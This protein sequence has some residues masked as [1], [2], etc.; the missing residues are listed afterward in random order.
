V[1]TRRRLLQAVA[2]AALTPVLGGC[3][4]S[5]RRKAA[6]QG[7][8]TAPGRTPSDAL[9]MTVVNQT[10]R[11]DNRSIWMYVVG[12]DLASGVQGYV[13]G[14]GLF[15]RCSAADNGPDG[16]ADFAIPL[17]ASGE[18]VM[19]L[20]RM[21]GRVYFA[22]GSKLR[23][24]VVD[25]S[26][27]QYPSPWTPGDANVSVLHDCIEFTHSPAGMFCNTTMVD[28]FSVPMALTLQG[29]RTQSTGALVAGGRRRIFEQISA[30]AAYR[31]LVV[32]DMRVVAPSHG[33]DAGLFPAGYFDP[34]ID[35]VWR[36]Y[37]AADLRVR[38]DK[39]VFTGRVRDHR[40]VFDGGVRPIARPSTRDALFCDG[41]LTAPNDG[42]TGP[43]A[44]VLGAGFNRSVLAVDAAQPVLDAAKFYREPVANHYAAVIHDNAADG[45]AYGFAF[46]DVGG[47]ASYIEDPAPQSLTVKLTA[48]D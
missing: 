9:S 39:G 26:R 44:A 45:R 48:F 25:G 24:R 30:L 4:S 22:L 23:F 42:V 11:F 32:G 3:D 40:L 34:M 10:G 36:R 33:L 46:D 2:A 41:A 29:A 28:M 27:L 5:K 35:R 31:K 43:V 17:A 18:T 14:D 6:A 19:R 21:S 38:T 47:H 16:D 13:R 20:P 15:K 8:P 7:P 37:E 12:T 1:V